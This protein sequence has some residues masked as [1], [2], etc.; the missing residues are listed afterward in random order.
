MARVGLTL[1]HAA[2]LFKQY[3]LRSCVQRRIEVKEDAMADGHHREDIMEAFRLS[4]EIVGALPCSKGS[5]KLIGLRMAS[6][7][8]ASL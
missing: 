3:L 8:H 6:R 4:L 7:I 5:A 1:N 2:N